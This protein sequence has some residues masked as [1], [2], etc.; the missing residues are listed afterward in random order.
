MLPVS[1]FIALPALQLQLPVLPVSLFLFLPALQLQLPKFMLLVKLLLLMFCASS[2]RMS[3]QAMLHARL[4]IPFAK[5]VLALMWNRN[6][7]GITC[8]SL[9]KTTVKLCALSVLYR[10]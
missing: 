7:Q 10:G 9:W 8:Q 3:R 1:Q 5:F 6:V 4:A 2:A